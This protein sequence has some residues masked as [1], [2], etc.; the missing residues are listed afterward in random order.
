VTLSVVIPTFNEAR[1]IG[2]ALDTVQTYL[3]ECHRGAELVI[4]DDGS[5]DHTPEI[6]TAAPAV[7]G[8][9]RQLVRLPR[10]RGKGAALRLGMAATTGQVTAF[11]DADLAYPLGALRHGIDAVSTGADLALGAR[12]LGGE[13]D[14]RAL[15]GLPRWLATHAFGS[16]VDKLLRLDVSDTQCGFKVFR[17]EIARK[18]FAELTFDGFAFDVELIWLAKHHGYVIER[19]PVAMRRSNRSGVR[20]V[21]DSVAMLADIAKLARRRP[22]L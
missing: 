5:T 12:D 21:R 11:F 16:L 17:G 7:D 18:L 8:V 4:A 9:T 2:A 14:T 6:V 22:G 10:N 20:L 1:G 3:A 19:F 15:Y 13:R